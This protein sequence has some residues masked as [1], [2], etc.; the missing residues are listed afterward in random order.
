[1]SQ[2]IAQVKKNSKLY[3]KKGVGWFK[4]L[5]ILNKVNCISSPEKKAVVASAGKAVVLL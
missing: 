5:P 4:K 3:K 1:M 2:E